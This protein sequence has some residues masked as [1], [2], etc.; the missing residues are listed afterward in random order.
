[1]IVIDKPVAYI[2][3]GRRRRSA[4]MVSTL[5]FKEG[6]DE[7]LDFGVRIGMKPT[8]LQKPYTIY[9]HFDV[10]GK[11]IEVALAAGAKPVRSRNIIEIAYEKRRRGNRR[12]RRNG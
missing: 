9:E 1:M 11:R 3:G 10:M 12:V 5:P 4:H 7:L 8:W 6:R 2:I